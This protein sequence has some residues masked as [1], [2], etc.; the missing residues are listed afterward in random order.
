MI[1]KLASSLGRVDEVPNIELAIEL[2]NDNDEIGVSE[3]VSGVKGKDKAISSDC[4]KVLYEIGN[5]KPELIADYA[6]DFLGMLMSKN[7]RLVWGSMMALATITDLRSDIVFTKLDNVKKAYASGSVITIDNSMT[8]FAKLCKA[9]EGYENEIFPFL[10]QHLSTC[11]P[12]EVSQHA[13]RIFICVN[14]KNRDSFCEVLE[15]R[16]PHLSKAQLARVNKLLKY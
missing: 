14:D 5:R 4:I 13:E 9:N 16:K 15:D 1:E 2:S 10:L 3:I 12:K 7:N 8:V 11:R 6:E